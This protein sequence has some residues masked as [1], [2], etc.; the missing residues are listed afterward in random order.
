MIVPRSDR[1]GRDLVNKM[2]FGISPYYYLSLMRCPRDG[3]VVVIDDARREQHEN[4][5]QR[6][7]D[8]VMQRATL[9][10]PKNVSA[11]CSPDGVHRKGRAGRHR[12]DFRSLQVY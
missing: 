11:N 9:V 12:V 7:H 4:N 6:D 3:F 2:A 1:R 10:L 8:V 5:D